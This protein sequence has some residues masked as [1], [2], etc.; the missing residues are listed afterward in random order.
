[1][2]EKGEK[3]EREGET[4]MKYGLTI[5]PIS[6]P[7]APFGVESGRRVKSEVKPRKKVGVGWKWV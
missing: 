5:T 1:M 2:L 6:H 4:E 7:L 3:C